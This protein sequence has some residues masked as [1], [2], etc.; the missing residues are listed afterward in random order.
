MGFIPRTQFGKANPELETN[1][2]YYFS[3]SPKS[4]WRPIIEQI[5]PS[6][7]N[8]IKET[9]SKEKSLEICSRYV[10]KGTLEHEKEIEEAI[11]F[12][13]Q[14]WLQLGPVYFRE[15]ADHF[16]T[17]WP[18]DHPII[19]GSV[20]ILPVYPRFL[21]KFSFFVGFKNFDKGREIIAHEILHFLWFKKWAEVFP[22]H[23]RSEYESPHLIWRL[24]EI[25]DPII[26]QCHPKI[27]AL[28]KPKNW[29]YSSFKEISIEGVSMTDYF[30]KI[31]LDHQQRSSSFEEIL[32]NVWQETN[33]HRIEI[34]K[35]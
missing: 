12:Y 28:I 1:L 31:Y 35:F 20:S 4:R 3:E 2:L 26:L 11:L 22:E 19:E 6:L 13:N 17:A 32:R 18:E 8:E 33:A 9:D 23:K 30:K 25:M 15:L 7:L 27:A 16:E 5:F 34:E 29:G 14:E 24:S 10:Q 21:D